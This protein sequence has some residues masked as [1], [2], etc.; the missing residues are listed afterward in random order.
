[1]ILDTSKLHIP[2]VIGHPFRSS[3]A[4]FFLLPGAPAIHRVL[5]GADLP[6]RGLQPIARQS[7][8]FLHELEEATDLLIGGLLKRDQQGNAEG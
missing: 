1:M 2:V 8:R 5:R 3:K 7:Q 4:L 6:I